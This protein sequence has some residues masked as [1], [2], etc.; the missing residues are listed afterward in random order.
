MVL[1]TNRQS[2]S[3]LDLLFLSV[4]SLFFVK[5]WRNSLEFPKK[6][7]MLNSAEHDFPCQKLMLK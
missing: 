6:N 4:K 1:K 3:Q 7:Y 2:G 5:F